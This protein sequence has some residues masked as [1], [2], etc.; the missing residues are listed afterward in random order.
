MRARSF[1]RE[2]PAVRVTDVDGRGRGR[3]PVN[4]R[5]LAWK[6]SF[7][8]LVQ[9]EVLGVRFVNA[10]ASNRTRSSRRKCEPCDDA[11]SATAFVARL[12]HLTE[13]TLE[14]DRSGVV[15]GAAR[16]APA[17]DPLDRPDHPVRRPPP[18]ESSARDT[19][20]SSCRSCP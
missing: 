4:S 18:R 9:V 17:D 5:R 13:E 11:S 3:D 20:S 12:E 6:Y 14:V 19:W 1:V 15:W 2:A 16:D 8:V 10:S 7:H